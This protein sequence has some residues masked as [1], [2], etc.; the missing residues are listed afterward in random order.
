MNLIGL[1]TKER[2]E[3]LSVSQDQLCGKVAEISQG[4]WI[5]TRHDIYRIEA[6]SRTVSELEA[7]VLAVAL[8]CELDWLV[9]GEMREQPLKEFVNRVFRGA[10]T[11]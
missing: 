1:R 10:V 5:P 8:D 9:S 7:L 6:G 2:R 11:P 4:A 3:L